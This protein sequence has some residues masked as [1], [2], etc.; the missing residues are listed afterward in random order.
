MSCLITRGDDRVE[1]VNQVQTD[2][3]VMNASLETDVSGVQRS[4][5][6]M[7]RLML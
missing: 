1:A 5:A 4:A 7:C 3:V 6:V 2:D